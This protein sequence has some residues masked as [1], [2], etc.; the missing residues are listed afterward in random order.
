M[1]QHQEVEAEGQ[2]RLPSAIPVLFYFVGCLRA[3]AD[4][5]ALRFVFL[6]YLLT[7]YFQVCRSK[8]SSS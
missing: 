3:F 4:L 2:P 7:S 1:R 5:K 6:F 8:Q